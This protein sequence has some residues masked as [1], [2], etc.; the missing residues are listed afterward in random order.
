MA[1]F[2]QY[3]YASHKGQAREVNVHAFAVHVVQEWGD[4][5]V[6]GSPEELIATIERN[7]KTLLVALCD[8]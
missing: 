1:D 4:T 2:I 6:N 7:V 8:A 5:G 3:A